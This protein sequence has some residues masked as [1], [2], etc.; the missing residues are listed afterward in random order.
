MSAYD[1]QSGLSG[2]IDPCELEK[3]VYSAS[4]G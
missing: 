2:L 4:I 3:N 1:I